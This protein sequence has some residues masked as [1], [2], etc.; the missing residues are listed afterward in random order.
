MPRIIEG[1]LQASGLKFAIVLSRFNHFV[2]DKLLAGALDGLV[3]HGAAEDDIEVF[4]APGSFELPAVARK[5]VSAKRHD[6][7]ICLGVLIRGDTPHF[8]YIS[9]EV[10]K[11]IAQVGM[12]TGVP[13]IY[14]VITADTL[15]QAIDRAG[16]KSGNKGFDAATAAIEMANL[17]AELKGRG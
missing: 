16:T 1:K 6:A 14:G 15:E 11:G 7:V 3:R 10:T 13:V 8:E 9:A 4:R 5:I 17:F 2:A 12:E